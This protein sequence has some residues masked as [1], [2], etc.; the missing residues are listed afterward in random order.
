MLRNSRLLKISFTS[1]NNNSIFNKK[2]M[3]DNITHSEI[4][5]L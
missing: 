4:R 5:Q 2:K 1:Q 3:F